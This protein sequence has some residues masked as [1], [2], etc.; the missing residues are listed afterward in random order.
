MKKIAL[1]TCAA[2]P[3]LTEQEQKV[4][5]QLALKRV[6]ATPTIWDDSQVDW[7][8]FEVII[9]RTIWDYYEKPASFLTW[10][11][12]LKSKGV[13]VFN[14]IPIIEWNLHKF[15]LKDIAQQ[16]FPVIPTYFLAKKQFQSLESLFT[17]FQTEMLIIK[18][19]ISAGAFHTYKIPLIEKVNFEYK[20]RELNQQYDLL[21]QPFLPEIQAQGEW[22]LLFF[23]GKYS[24]AVLKMPQSGDFRVQ[25]EHGG[26]TKFYNPPPETLQLTQSIVNTYTPDLLFTRVDGVEIQ[27]RF[28]LMELELIEPELFLNS[29]E[30]VRKFAEAIMLKLS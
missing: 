29:D 27:G 21:V 13:K 15:Y 10:L 12:E 11:T 25:E 17:H 2:L 22:S 28:H 6:A 23:N 14:P 3:T 1:A 9:I 7:M 5:H 18:P 16:G 30:L 8:D 24:H 26:A 4:I 20:I 19:A